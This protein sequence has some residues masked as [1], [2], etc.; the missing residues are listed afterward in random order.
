[1][2]VIGLTGGM[3]TGKSEASRMLQELGAVLINADQVG[4]ETYAPG[5]EA[6]RAV[7]DAFGEEVLHPGGEVDRKR[8]G[9]IVFADPQALATLNAIMHPRIAQAVE[10]RIQELKSQGVR[11]IVLEAALLIEAN[12]TPLVDEVWVTVAPEEAA[13]QRVKARSGMP[14]ESIR[15]R[16]ANQLPQAELVRRAHAVIENAGELDDLREA[17]ADL[18]GKRILARQVGNGPK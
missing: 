14:E 12:W 6:W 9:S 15:S 1:M 11:V 4:H 3:G 10:K 2:V 16:I 18:W 8:L 5:T 7:V 13:V 17:V